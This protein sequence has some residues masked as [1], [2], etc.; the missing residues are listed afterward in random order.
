VVDGLDVHPDA[1]ALEAEADEFARDFLID[2]EQW[3]DFR[4]IGY[5]GADDIHEFAHSIGIAP[6]IVVGRLQKEGLVPYNRLT[7]LKWTYQWADHN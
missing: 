6:F 2:P 4:S 5:F 3:K 7:R 1:G